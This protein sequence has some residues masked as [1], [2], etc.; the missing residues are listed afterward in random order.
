MK[1]RTLLV[2]LLFALIFVSCSTP[3]HERPSSLVQFTPAVLDFGSVRASSQ[4]VE[5]SFRIENKS[6]QPLTI[7]KADLEA[8]AQALEEGILQAL[9][10]AGAMVVNPNCSV[11][12]G[13]CQGVIGPGE[14]LISTGTRNFK[15]RAGSPES[16]VYLASAA[17]VAASAVKG[18]I[19]T[20][21]TFTY[22]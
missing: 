5:L 15:G 8:F 20:A 19:T 13:A 7:E 22:L 3:D 11:C 9:N 16:F 4:P 14:V 10:A 2:S 12:W 18:E 1:Q 17:T 6:S 21:D